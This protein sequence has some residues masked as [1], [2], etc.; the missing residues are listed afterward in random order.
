MILGNEKR[1]TLSGICRDVSQVILASVLVDPVA[2]GNFNSNF[3]ISG[4]LV[5]ITLWYISL[6]LIKH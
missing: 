3:L 1:K 6:K 4:A 2:R 5:T